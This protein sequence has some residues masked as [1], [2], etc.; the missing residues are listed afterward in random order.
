MIYKGKV[1]GNA[2]IMDGNVKLPDGLLVDIVV[3][4]TES[5]QGEKDSTGICGLWQDERDAE[6]IIR[7]LKK[8]RTGFG[9]GGVNL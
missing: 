6:E 1:K 3:P 8:A 5:T 4:K 2:I 9:S 7:D